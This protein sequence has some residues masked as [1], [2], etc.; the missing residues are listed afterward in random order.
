MPADLGQVLKPIGKRSF[1]HDGAEILLKP[2]HGPHFLG[3]S[4]IA[5]MGQN[6]FVILDEK[7]NAWN[8]VIDSDRS[9]GQVANRHRLFFRQ[10]LKNQDRRWLGFT[11]DSGKVRPN[12]VVKL[13]V[14]TSKLLL[15]PGLL[16]ARFGE[17]MRDLCTICRITVG[18]Q[19]LI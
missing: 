15:R 8:D 1:E 6:L 17:L 4:R 5:D 18:K 14:A 13:M 10:A 7:R 16:F 11:R 9:H 12:A 19:E 2:G 3:W